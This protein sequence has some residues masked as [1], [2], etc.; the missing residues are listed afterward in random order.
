MLGGLKLFF[1]LP[2]SLILRL[3]ANVDLVKSRVHVDVI[4]FPI[5]LRDRHFI[6]SELLLLGV[7]NSDD[8][9]ARRQKQVFRL[10]RTSPPLALEARK[11]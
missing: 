7:G 4:G 5:P 1:E 8:S 9:K 2:I 3:V 10:L 6:G 11:R